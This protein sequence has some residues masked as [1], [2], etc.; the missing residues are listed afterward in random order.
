MN[1]VNISSRYIVH[2]ISG[3]HLSAPVTGTGKKHQLNHASLNIKGLTLASELTLTY[4]CVW[5]LFL[6]LQQQSFDCMWWKY[7]RAALILWIFQG[8][9]D[10]RFSSLSG[11]T[12]KILGGGTSFTPILSLFIEPT[13]WFQFQLWHL[14][15]N[16]MQFKSKN[17]PI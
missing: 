2:K 17:C 4:K 9:S 3:P 12:K 14:P 13:Q 15:W 11:G 1:I 6:F 10:R 5:D 16:M 8:T 7:S